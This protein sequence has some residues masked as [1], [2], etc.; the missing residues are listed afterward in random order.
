[1]SYKVTQ[2]NIIVIPL[3]IFI[4]FCIP[5]MIL[6][7]L[8]LTLQSYSISMITPIQIAYSQSQ[9]QDVN[10]LLKEADLFFDQGNESQAIVLYDKVLAIEPKNVH[11][12]IKKG[13]SLSYLGRYNEAMPLLEKSLEIDLQ[14]IDALYYKGVTLDFQGKY[15]EAITWYDKV[16][17]I[18]PKYP[19]ALIDK[20][21]ALYS[22][23]KYD[24]AITWYDKVLEIDPKD[25]DTL[26]GKALTLYG[27]GMYEESLRWYDKVL[28]IDPKDVDVLYGK[29]LALYDLGKYQESISWYDKVLEID[30]EYANAIYAKDLA[31]EKAGYQTTTGNDTEPNKNQDL[32]TKEF[33]NLVRNQVSLIFSEMLSEIDNSYTN[34]E[35]GLHYDFPNEWK[36]TLIN[37]VNSLIVSPPGVN[38]TSYMINA[39]ENTLYSLILSVDPSSKDMTQEIFQTAINSVMSEVFQSLEQIGP[40]ISVSAMSK[41]SIKSF[42]NLSEVE[43]PTESL[44]S[45]WYEY[46]FSVM[47]QMVGNITEGTNPL[48]ATKIQSINHSETNGIPTEISIIETELPQSN[49][50]YKTLS[51]LFL[52]PDNILNIEYS[53]NMESYEKYRSEFENSVKTIMLTNP[54]TINEQNI[55]LFTGP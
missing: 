54:S 13:A 7:F 17:K 27:K 21:G 44:A 26:Y 23:K 46:T 39:T 48:G 29:G 19:D 11:A 31:L 38:V 6:L 49:N 5:F 32:L 3:S 41:D 8:L 47:N 25:L 4:V 55:K 10:K 24:E 22:L 51:Y 52:T 2:Y 45:I 20:A 53:A 34:R 12:L 1:M 43:P 40:T 9:L 50:H 28:E 35:L 14:N 36:G 30:S 33:Q 42:Q 37:P 16:I 15:D 18:D